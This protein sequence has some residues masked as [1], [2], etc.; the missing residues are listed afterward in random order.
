MKLAI[1]SSINGH[2]NILQ[3]V[4]TGLTILAERSE[5][6]DSVEVLTWKR[7]LNESISFSSKV[8]IIETY[9][10]KKSLSILKLLFSIK[11]QDDMVVLYNLMPTAYGNSNFANLV[12]LL[13]PLFNKIVF[14]NKVLV[15]Y[16][17]STFTNDFKKLGYNGMINFFKSKVIYLLETILFE[18]ITVLTLNDYYPVKIK[19][20]LPNSKVEFMEIPFFPVLGSLYLN[21]M[22]NLKSINSSNNGI[23]KILLFGYWGPQKDL[24]P[25][26]D[27]LKKLREN[28]DLFE[29]IIAG[30]VNPH[31]PK[32]LELFNK[33]MREYSDI[34][35]QR[36]EFV[37][38]K[39]LF[40][41]FLSVDLVLISYTS[42]GGFSSVLSYAMFFKKYILISDFPEFRNQAKD[43]NKIV[44]FTRENFC[45]SLS[46]I[47]KLI[48][49]EQRNNQIIISDRIKSMS[50]KFTYALNRKT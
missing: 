10:P 49:N 48:N 40:S 31:F 29:L 21:N 19:N 14:K 30:E 8:N 50:E 15:L 46:S 38:E 37:A 35:D 6:I 22:T 18:H 36:K 13:N 17:N 42:P 24:F 32:Y 7:D 2:G 34:I 25:I 45:G 1:V 9:D 16:H 20:K 43:Y 4:G 39:D 23:T 3:E 44:F 5:E 28:G 33:K 47:I 41:L 12:G 26:L 11:H 27:N